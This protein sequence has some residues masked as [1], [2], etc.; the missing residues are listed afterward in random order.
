MPEAGHSAGQARRS[1]EEQ[2]AGEQ[3]QFQAGT[4]T[5]FPVLQ[6]QIDLI[7]ARSREMRAR[8]DA[9]E[10]IANLER[11]TAETIVRCESQAVWPHAR[12]L[13]GI[14]V[15]HRRTS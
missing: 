8:A 5:W 3:R 15:I 1:A 10:P 12:A 14:G 9:G 6:R 13:G 2:Y 11:A 7:A 4:S